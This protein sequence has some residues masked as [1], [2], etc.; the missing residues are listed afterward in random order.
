MEYIKNNI[1]QV[2]LIVV[3]GILVATNI[4]TLWSVNTG[5][6]SAKAWH[7]YEL[8]YFVDKESYEEHSHP[9]P[10]SGVSQWQM[11]NLVMSINSQIS[12]LQDNM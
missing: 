1:I 4:Y 2:I 3:V 12:E 11:D 7:E 10:P 6:N 8:G 5:F 9:V